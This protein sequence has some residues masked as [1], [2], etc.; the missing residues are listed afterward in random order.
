MKISNHRELYQITFNHSSDIDF[1]SDINLVL[2]NLFCFKN[3]ILK[4]IQNLII[5]IV[6]KIGDE[7]LQHDVNRE[8]IKYLHYHRVN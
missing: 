5:T 2:D 7:K 6:D 3:N 4:R 8:A 1:K